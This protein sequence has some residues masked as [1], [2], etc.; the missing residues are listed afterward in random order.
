VTQAVELQLPVTAQEPV[1]HVA[2]VTPLNPELQTGVQVVPLAAPAAQFP[3]PPLGMVGCVGQAVEVQ[4]PVMDQEP[5]LHVAEVTPANPELQTGVHTVPL[6]D[7]AAQL[8][9]PP[10]VTVGRVAQAV[11][12]HV[13][14]MDQE[15]ELHVA[16]VTPLNPELQTGVH[17]VP[18][19]A[20]AAQFPGPPL[21]MVG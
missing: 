20:P 2:D 14:A 3:G 7:P 16:E 10:F 5:E 13:P 1:L 8:P 11:E 21:V 9:G 15:P 19:A 17:V 6:A 4:V 18:L 12:L